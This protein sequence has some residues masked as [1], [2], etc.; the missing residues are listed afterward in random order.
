MGL[1]AEALAS[2]ARRLARPVRRF[3]LIDRRPPDQQMDDP[4][5]TG[6]PF[7]LD[8]LGDGDADED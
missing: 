2:T 3:G 8:E 6:E 1:A 4:Y 5:Q 7:W